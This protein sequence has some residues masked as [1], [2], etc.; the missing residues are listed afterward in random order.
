MD[1]RALSEVKRQQSALELLLTYSWAFIIIAVFVAVVFIVLG[2]K[3]PAQYLPTQCNIQPLLP[4]VQTLL[5][6][7]GTNTLS[8]Y[9]VLFVNNLGPALT[10]PANGFSINT[11]NIGS[12]GNN[13]YVGNCTPSFLIEGSEALCNVYIT[14]SYFPSAGTEASVAFTIS[15]GI[16]NGNTPSSCPSTIYK[17]TG[18]SIQ[19]MSSPVLNLYR[20]SFVTDSNGLIVLNGRS[21]S[22]GTSVLLPLG[23]YSVYAS[24]MSGY[25]FVSW[26]VTTGVTVVSSSSQV[27]NATLSGNSTLA[28]NFIT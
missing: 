18:Y 6:E 20:L 4:C 1:A 24:P 19:S 23:K 9:K 13:D 16:C 3:P 28:A 2:A 12:V 14:G 11:T 25:S 15:Y 22:G 26:S 7:P 8:T 21:F 17:S 27:T 10:M 5:T